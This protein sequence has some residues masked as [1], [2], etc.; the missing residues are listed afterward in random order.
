MADDSPHVLVCVIAG[1]VSP[2]TVE[3]AGNKSVM[4]LKN[5]IREKAIKSSEDVVAK[6]LTLWKVRMTLVV[7]RSDITGNT[8]LA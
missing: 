7:I 4:D 5:L 8:T 6:D 2:F 3:L 1:E